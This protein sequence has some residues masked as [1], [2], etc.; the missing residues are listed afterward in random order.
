MLSLSY[1]RYLFRAWASYRE[2]FHFLKSHIKIQ[3]YIKDIEIV[4]NTQFF[5]FSAEQFYKMLSQVFSALTF[6][7]LLALAMAKT[8]IFDEAASAADNVFG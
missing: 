4:F 5:N 2:K 3:Y 7:A 8:G 6:A 1:E